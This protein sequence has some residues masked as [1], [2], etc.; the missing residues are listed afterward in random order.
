MGEWIKKR[1]VVNGARRIRNENLREHQYREGYAKC[2]EN[3]RV[4]W[5]G[6]SSIEHMWEWVKG[7]WFKVQERCLAR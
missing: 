5:D 7:Q 1:E 6:E 2:L 3:K 4:E